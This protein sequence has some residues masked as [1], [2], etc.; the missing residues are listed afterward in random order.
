MTNKQR[1]V[2]AIGDIHGCA[3]ELEA[4]LRKIAPTPHDLIVFLG[5]YVDR[6]PNSQRVIDI[7]LDLESQCEVVALMGNHEHMFLDFLE[8]PESA[9]AGLFILNGGASTL[10]S[11]AGPAGSFDIPETHIRFLKS[12]KLYHEVETNEGGY[13]FVHAGVPDVALSKLNPETHGPQLL[14]IR[15]PFLMSRYH[16]EKIVVHGHTPN[17]EPDVRPNRINLDTGCVYD[18]YLTAM[19]LP[20]RR[21]IQVEKGIKGE[22]LL[23]PKSIGS[24]SRVAMRFAGTLPVRA[25]RPGETLNDYETLNFNQFGLLIRDVGP[26]T[27]RTLSVGDVLEGTVGRETSSKIDFVGRVVRIETRMSGP[28]AAFLYGVQIDRVTAGAQGRYWIDRP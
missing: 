1:R 22:P 26:A 10:A 2:F 28:D 18:G 9:G 4:L 3:L 25:G 16:W 17:I 12:L 11:Y 13:F 14:W 27:M 6:G 8:R 15:Q 21:V 7:I 19:E 23:F 5:D 20:S 24:G